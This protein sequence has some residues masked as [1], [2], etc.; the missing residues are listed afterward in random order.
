MDN[1]LQT[2]TLPGNQVAEV[3]LDIDYH[4]IE[5]FS[6][7]LYSSPNKAI[8]ELVVNGYDAGAD[9]VR[10]YLPGRYTDKVIVWDDG[11][12]MNV[13]G[14]QRLWKL[15]DSP[16]NGTNREIADINGIERKV[17]GK[18]GIGKIASYTVGNS[19]SHYCK[20]VNGFFLVSVEYDSLMD[21]N[22]EN[23][24]KTVPI[25]ELTSI[26]AIDAIKSYFNEV[27]A[28]VDSLLATD[29]WT[30]A[31]IDKLKRNDVKQGR[32]RWV[33]GN[34]LP[35]QPTFRVYVDETQ[36]DSKL[37]KTGLKLDWTFSTPEIKS[38]LDRV[39]KDALADGKVDGDLIYGEEVGLD[40]EKPDQNI[41]FVEFPKIGKVWGRLRLYNT[42]LFNYKKTDEGR[43]HG[44]FIYVRNRLVN[45][46]DDKL[47]LEGDP[48]YLTFYNAQIILHIDGLDEDLLADRERI[49]EGTDKIAEL[50]VLQNSV[51]KAINKEQ[52]TLYEEDQRRATVDY[53]F[54]VT[55]PSLFMEPLAALWVKNGVTEE[56][57]FD[58]RNPKISTLPLG[59]SVQVSNF[60][61]QEGFKINSLHP[62]YQKL[63][64]ELGTGQVSAKAI[65]EFEVIAVSEL[66]FTGYL[67]D[68][69]VTNEQ[70]DRIM[71]WRDD[72][73]RKL[74][75]RD[76]KNPATLAQN[77]TE[78]S[79]KS[80]E[81]FENAI[82][83]VLNSIG[84]NAQRD[85]KKG[86]KDVFVKAF[87]GDSSYNLTFEAKAMTSADENKA[88]PNDAAETGGANN[89]RDMVGADHAVII[90]R[91]FAGF[92]RNGEEPAILG[93]CRSMGTVS[94]MTVD[95][96]I[97]LLFAVKEHAYSLNTIK[98]VFTEIETPDEKL[99]RIA[100]LERPL[101]RIDWVKLLGH[102]WEYQGADTTEGVP[103]PI[104][105]IWLSYG[106][107][108]NGIQEEVFRSV[109][110]ALRTLAFPL[111]QFSGES[112][113]FLLQSPDNV[114]SRIRNKLIVD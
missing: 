50:T 21:R 63:R 10:V 9:W 62:Y 110:E 96:L 79:Y 67:Y 6:K 88:L 14:I 61:V 97:K 20:T 102:I 15:A 39:W 1:L 66:L 7:H 16:K 25:Q 82:V 94:I 112:D 91:K 98:P 41:A 77:L 74:A 72:L 27:P 69:G 35:V 109:L 86:Q 11:T 111:V 37:L 52:R 84:F 46:D 31:V 68:L 85:G 87:C 30:F 57:G 28:N 24:R 92:A 59:Q 17:I 73:Y 48:S 43:S 58:F 40:K 32:L 60:S 2:L 4:I 51:Y 64:H 93:E 56:L 5:H 114:I 38:Y 65:K 105:G 33:I 44:F 49:T 95:A 42:S 70:V 113:I 29:S 71:R 45:L 22:E 75:E 23:K 47:F 13:E 103:V 100:S 81:P 106:Y 34:A 18:F 108:K 80:G 54:P 26:E 104:K 19:I 55:S 36:V 83:E 76:K 107:R 89:H 12:S 8:E 90:A 99:V 53:I 101:D 78:A 3:T